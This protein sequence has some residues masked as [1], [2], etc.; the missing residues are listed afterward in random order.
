MMP[1]LDAF[2]R[3]PI[4]IRLTVWYS[5]VFAAALFCISVTCLWMVHRATEDLE[6]NELQQRVRSVRRFLEARPKDESPRELH[7]AITAAYDS[8]HGNKWLQV[9]DEHGEWLYRSPHVSAVYPGLIPPQLAQPEGA[10][11]AY[12]AESIHVRALIEPITVRGVRYTV[13]TGLSL[14]KTL[15][16]LSN[17]RAQLF[18]LTGLGLLVSSLAGYLMSRKALAPIAIIAAEAQRIND[19]NLNLRLPELATRDELAALSDTLN[20]MLGRIEAGY[21]SVRS[22]TANAAHELRSPVALLRAETEVA[23][24]FPRD[25]AYYRNT[26]E[27][28]LQNAQHMSR[29]IDQLLSLARADAGTEVLQPEALNLPELLEEAAGDWSAQFADAQIR[30]G[31]E[32]DPGELW[33]EADYIA[34]KRLLNILLENAWRYT[35]P[36]QSVT[37][38]LRTKAQGSNRAVAEVTVAD[39]GIGISPDDQTRV[40]QRFCRAA[41]PL[42]GDFAGS[43]LGLVL[44]QWIAE[45]HGS[46]IDLKS[47][48]GSGSRFSLTLHPITPPAASIPALFLSARAQ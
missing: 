1:R 46:A 27:H 8:S 36:G 48:L 40:F 37:L 29:L 32:L 25:A 42:R 35:P 14:S 11:F 43:G 15:T 47:S 13:Q 34:F 6:N 10:Y 4:R 33:I 41:Q 20:L 21:L 12:T 7:D 39:T 22:F 38:V 23:L 45:R 16:I 17:F 24:S 18:L 44:A 28:V 9:I 30:F 3:L 5:L 2:H 19:R 31:V 26:C